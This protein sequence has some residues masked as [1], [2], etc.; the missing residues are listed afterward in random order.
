MS[1]TDLD[2]LTDDA[3]RQRMRAFLAEHCPP[4]LRNP[5]KRLHLAEARP[6]YD[7]L[8]KQGWLAPGWPREHGGMGLMVMLGG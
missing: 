2:A 5:V 4:E 7:I 1:D 8:S 3:F 6:W